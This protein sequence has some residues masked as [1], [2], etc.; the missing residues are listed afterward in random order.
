MSK[1]VCA[2]NVHNYYECLTKTR[3]KLIKKPKNSSNISYK[4]V[5]SHFLAKIPRNTQDF[6]KDFLISW[7]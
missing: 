2:V 1:V 4:L 5:L 6:N 7:Y 3:H